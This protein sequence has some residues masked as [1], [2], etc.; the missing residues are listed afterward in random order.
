MNF[1]NKYLTIQIIYQKVVIHL[2]EI[3]KRLKNQRQIKNNISE[4]KENASIDKR[5]IAKKFRE[6]ALKA[7]KT[8]GTKESISFFRDKLVRRRVDHDTLLKNYKTTSSPKPGSMLVYTYDPKHKDKLPFYDTNPCI[9]LLDYTKDGWYGANLHYLPPTAR[10][11]LLVEIGWN[12]NVS[13]FNIAK[14]LERNKITKHCLK[15][16]LRNQLNSRLKVVNREDW[17]IIIQLPFDAFVNESR[18]RIWRK[19]KR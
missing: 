11:D 2:M 19:V 5:T 1:C 17:E 14:A 4:K 3:N 13:L 10:A 15:R 6:L 16:Y 18:G 7:Q 12:K 8:L 9:I